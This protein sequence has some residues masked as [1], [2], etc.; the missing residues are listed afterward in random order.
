MTSQYQPPVSPV[1]PPGGQ[2]QATPAQTMNTPV[3]Y[4]PDE[5][6]RMLPLEDIDVV[7]AEIRWYVHTYVRANGEVVLQTRGPNVGKP[8]TA[9]ALRTKFT[10]PDGT[11]HDS[12]FYAAGSPDRYQITE[13]GRKLVSGGV[14]ALVADTNAD[15]FMSRLEAVGFPID[16]LRQGDLGLIDGTGVHLKMMPPP[17]RRIPDAPSAGGSQD[18]PQQGSREI[19][20]P[21]TLN[22]LPGE[23]PA[24]ATST[25]APAAVVPP[26]AANPVAGNVAAQPVAAQPET[27]AA[28]PAQSTTVTPT[29]PTAAT[30]PAAVPAPDDSAD[31]VYSELDEALK[32]QVA[33]TKE[34]GQPSF[35]RSLIITSIYNANGENQEW[36]TKVIESW[37][38]GY[39]QARVGSLITGFDGVNVQV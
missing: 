2:V 18:Q 27:T 33:A 13:G 21:S 4:A 10:L 36:A 34:A 28:P 39:L 5:S 7:I 20:V 9:L 14:S 29:A 24:Q 19:P 11:S 26:V 31:K 3:S 38:D 17:D 37:N 6:V 35:P 12:Q 25:P 22:F 1:T 8:A 23:A 15:F 32:S 30:V 16:R